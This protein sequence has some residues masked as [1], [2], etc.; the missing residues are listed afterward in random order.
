MR[1]GSAARGPAAGAPGRAERARARLG[2]RRKRPFD[3]PR[4]SGRLATVEGGTGGCTR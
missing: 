1:D 3:R 2:A 4:N